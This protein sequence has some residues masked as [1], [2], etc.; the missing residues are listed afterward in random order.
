MTISITSAR[1][2]L[3]SLKRTILE[4]TIRLVAVVAFCTVLASFT[5]SVLVERVE[6]R[7]VED[8][9]TFGTTADTCVR[10]ACSPSHFAFD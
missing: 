1:V 2:V 5:G 4:G 10:A 6:K 7:A 9:L 8:R 3:R